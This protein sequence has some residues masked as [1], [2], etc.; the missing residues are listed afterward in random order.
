MQI[1]QLISKSLAKPLQD[2][3]S[4]KNKRTPKLIVLDLVFICL[5]SFKFFFHLFLLVVLSR[6]SSTLFGGFRLSLQSLL[7]DVVLFH[8][9][10][11]RKVVSV[12]FSHVGPDVVAGVEK[13]KRAKGD[14]GV[15]GGFAHFGHGEIAT[16]SGE[17]R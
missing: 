10:V 8:N 17:R 9:K 5:V 2:V 13:E 3:V 14:F 12:E 15:R 7:V 6:S 4:R 16:G 1:I 11:I